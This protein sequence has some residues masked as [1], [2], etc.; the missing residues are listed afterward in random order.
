MIAV[1]PKNIQTLGYPLESFP[2][3]LRE[4]G[5][6]RVHWT[7]NPQSIYSGTQEYQEQTR[8][9]RPRYIWYISC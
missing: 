1:Q 5:G 9:M 7:V 8:M 4:L 2:E 6:G 3:A